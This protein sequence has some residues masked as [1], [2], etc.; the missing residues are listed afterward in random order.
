MEKTPAV[1]DPTPLRQPV[2]IP[3][4]PSPPEKPKRL[5]SG[6]S[7]IRDIL[8]FVIGVCLIIYEVVI[9]D[10]VRPYVLAVGLTM[11]GLPL[12][13]GAD[14]RRKDPKP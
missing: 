9:P 11:A 8:T 7:T 2:V 14:E 12:V 5:P 1:P 3:P 4:M 6:F 10:E 13:F